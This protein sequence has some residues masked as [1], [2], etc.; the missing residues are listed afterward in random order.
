[1]TELESRT[2]DELDLLANQRSILRVMRRSH[3]FLMAYVFSPVFAI[4]IPMIWV[5]LLVAMMGLP[6][7]GLS[8]AMIIIII[9]VVIAPLIYKFTKEKFG[10]LRQ[11]G[12]ALKEIEDSLGEKDIATGLASYIF[13]IFDVLRPAD[14]RDATPSEN[15]VEKLRR[16]LANLTKTVIVEVISQGVLYAFL[17]IGFLIPEL[18]S[19]IQGGRPL[20]VPLSALTII[21]VILAARWFTFFYWRLLVRRW[22]RF[23]QGFIAWGQELER[24]LSNPTNNHDGRPPS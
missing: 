22:L 10:T 13:L 6:P 21:L 17:I 24:K 23:Y 7:G 5:I 9:P 2:P 12:A 11:A 20:L 14:G 1:M 8:I 15:E 18:V 19:A 4:Y 16:H 3:R